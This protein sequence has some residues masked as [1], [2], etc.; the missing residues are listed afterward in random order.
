MHYFAASCDTPDVNKQFGESLG[1]D[2][3]ILSDPDKTIAK[4]YGVVTPERELP[5]RWTYYIGGDGKIVHIDKE[6][7]PATAG[8]DVAARLK[9]L[10]VPTRTN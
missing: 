3:P 1:L 6:V 7:K 9:A 5:F 2:F 8:A 4:A 10:A